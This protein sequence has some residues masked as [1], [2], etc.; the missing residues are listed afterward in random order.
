MRDSFVSLLKL[1]SLNLSWNQEKHLFLLLICISV[2]WVNI[3]KTRDGHTLAVFYRLCLYFLVSSAF[4]TAFTSACRWWLIANAQ[5][6]LPEGCFSWPWG[7]H[8]GECRTAGEFPAAALNQCQ[9]ENWWTNGPTFLPIFWDK[10]VVY[11]MLSLSSPVEWSSG[12]S[13]WK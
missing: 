6:C 7:P 13:Q 12:C 4:N 5:N 9:K 3:R 1:N 8:I 2:C 11:F 10:S